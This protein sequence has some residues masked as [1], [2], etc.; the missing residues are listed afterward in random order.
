MRILIRQPF[1][2]F[3]Q[4]AVSLLYALPFVFGLLLVTAGASI[5]LTADS[6]IFALRRIPEIATRLSDE[7]TRR[8][9]VAGFPYLWQRQ[10]KWFFYGIVVFAIIGGWFLMLFALVFTVGRLFKV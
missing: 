6:V 7:W 10:L 4:L 3:Q 1:V 9:I 2:L 5:K 8:A